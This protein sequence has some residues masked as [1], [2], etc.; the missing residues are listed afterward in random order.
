MRKEMTAVIAGFSDYQRHIVVRNPF[1]EED[2]P[3]LEY[4]LT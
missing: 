2:W 4:G 3:L 1:V